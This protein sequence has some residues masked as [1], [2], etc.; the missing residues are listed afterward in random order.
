MN[1]LIALFLSF[2]LATA[3]FSQRDSLSMNTNATT[4]SGED[5]VLELLIKMAMENPRIKSAEHIAI[6][7]EYI[8]RRDRTAF[9]NQLTVSGN[10]NE[11]SIK[12][13]NN[14]DV[15]RQSTVYPRYNIGLQIPLGLFINDKK[16]TTSNF[17]RYQSMVDNVHVEEQTIRREVTVLYETYNMTQALVALQLELLDDSKIV[18]ERNEQDF[19]AGKL[20]LEAYSASV[21]SYNQEK[22]KQVNLTF[23]LSQTEAYMEELIGMKY[24]DAL[25][26]INTRMTGR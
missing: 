11:I 15:V 12:G 17:N 10:L 6:Y 19:E 2:F 9:L 25:V 13:Y 14:A 16:I 1:K 21:R 20:S 4:M 8:W 3:A 24:R 5:S 7:T 22:V 26:L 23:T 18:F